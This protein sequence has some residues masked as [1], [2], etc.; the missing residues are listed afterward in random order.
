M[1]PKQ[2]LLF[3]SV[4]IMCAIP[5]VSISP[6]MAQSV[7]TTS[8]S[9]TKLGKVARELYRNQQ[10]WYAYNLKNYRYTLQIS[11]FCTEEFRQ[12]VIIEVRNGKLKSISRPKGGATIDLEAFERYSTIPK[13]FNLVKKAIA[14]KADRITVSYNPKYGYPTSISIDQSEMIA[15]EEIYLTISNFQV[16]SSPFPALR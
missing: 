8:V 13:L 9:N 1:Q 6:V 4:L 3:V 5:A 11:C 12:P 16:I 2:L 7:E 14:D 10:R 15:D